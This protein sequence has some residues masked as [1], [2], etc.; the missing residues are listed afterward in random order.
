MGKNKLSILQSELRERLLLLQE[1]INDIQ[2]GD[3]YDQNIY[4]ETVLEI[5]F[6]NKTLSRIWELKHN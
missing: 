1:D 4:K 3:E 2:S 6:I 5:E